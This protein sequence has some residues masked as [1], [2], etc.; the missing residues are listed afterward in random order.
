MRVERIGDLEQ[1]VGPARLVLLI[2]VKA[3]VLV[4]DSEL[5]GDR[6]K[7][8]DL[9]VEPHTCRMCVV[10]PEQAEHAAVED[11]R[12]D[13][14]RARLKRLGKKLEGRI[15]D[16]RR[17]VHPDRIGDIKPLGQALGVE[18]NGRTFALRH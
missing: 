8:A 5:L 7:K 13:E 15:L 1:C 9:L 3:R 18:R 16:E 6:L 11:D 12:D 2:D 17:I 14:Q 4:T 10:Q